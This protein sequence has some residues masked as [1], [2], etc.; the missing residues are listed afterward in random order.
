MQGN[1]LVVTEDWVWKRWTDTVKECM[2]ERFGH[3]ASKENNA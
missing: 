2:K 1:G 3:P